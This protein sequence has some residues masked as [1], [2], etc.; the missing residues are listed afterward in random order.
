MA[1]VCVWGT[2]FPWRLTNDHKDEDKGG[3]TCADVEH[4]SDVI[5]QL[6]H[7]I[8]IRHKDGWNQEPNGNAHLQMK[9]T[10]SEKDST[11]LTDC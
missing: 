4:D 1:S 7:I 6:V 11:A 2:I 9:G 10:K 3:N 8:H 5:R